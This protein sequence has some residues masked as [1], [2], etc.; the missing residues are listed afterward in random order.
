[1]LPKI[2]AE[3]WSNNESNETLDSQF[4]QH[5]LVYVKEETPDVDQWRNNILQLVGG[6]HHVQC[7]YN[8]FPLIPTN[9]KP[10]KKEK[11]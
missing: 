3:L 10:G 11:C 9:A 4:K 8:Q 5:V 6:T 2:V 1:M 7:A